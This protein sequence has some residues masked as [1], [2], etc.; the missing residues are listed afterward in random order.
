MA[1]LGYIGAQNSSN[2]SGN[3]S[4]VGL[5]SYCNGSLPLSKRCTF[6]NFFYFVVAQPYK[7]VMRTSS[8][9]SSLRNF[10]LLIFKFRSK[11][12]MRRIYAVP[13]IT[14]MAN[15]HSFW[16]A[17]FIVNLPRISVCRNWYSINSKVSISR[18]RKWTF[19]K[20][21]SI[22]FDKAKKKFGFWIE[23]ALM[24]KMPFV[25]SCFSWFSFDFNAA[26]FA[27]YCDHRVNML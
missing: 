12:E 24:T 11:P 9:A 19:P 10:V 23:K 2:D 25:F 5:E 8:V 26:V 15:A 22:S 6:S 21:A 7:V 27:C 20:P 13:H 18:S 3:T 17:G 4:L 16:N 14:S 1:E